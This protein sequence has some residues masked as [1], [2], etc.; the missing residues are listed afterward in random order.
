M[1][2]TLIK[3]IWRNYGR[4]DGEKE[5]QDS[6]V[7]GRKTE[8]NWCHL[9]ANASNLNRLR[10]SYPVLHGVLT[11]IWVHLK[12]WFTHCGGSPVSLPEYRPLSTPGQL[13]PAT[14]KNW[15][16]LFPSLWYHFL[17]T[18]EVKCQE[19]HQETKERQEGDE[20]AENS[21]SHPP[22]PKDRKQRENTRCLAVIKLY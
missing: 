6:K 3:T 8:Q 9:K 11:E 18:K 19:L 21:R 10:W 17:S 15:M 2:R 7:D 14:Q 12:V 16:A 4:Q 1:G 22:S 20:T 5:G 13:L